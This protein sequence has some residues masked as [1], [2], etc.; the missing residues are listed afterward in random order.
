MGRV[1]TCWPRVRGARKT[2]AIGTFVEVELTFS[3]WDWGRDS[4]QH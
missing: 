1:E 3:Q 2:L 4:Q